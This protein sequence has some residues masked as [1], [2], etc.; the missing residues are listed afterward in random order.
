MGLI[1]I[2]NEFLS[3]TVDEYSENGHKATL[4]ATDSNGL[5]DIAYYTYWFDDYSKEFGSM[6]FFYKIAQTDIAPFIRKITVRGE[7]EGVN[8]TQNWDLA[9][10]LKA[11]PIFTHLEEFNLPLNDSETHHQ[12]IVTY[13]DMYNENGALGFLLDAAPKLKSLTAPSAPSANFFERENHSLTELNLQ[14]G[15]THQNFIKNLAASTCFSSVAKL[16]FRDYAQTYMDDYEKDCV[17]YEQ[18]EALFNATGLPMLKEITLIAT[19]IT[20]EQQAALAKQAESKGIAL[21]FLAE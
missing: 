10:L 17:P 7:D 18:Y 16:T 15:Y 1:D 19:V 20:A 2:I 6:P 11:K 9:T 13:D 12:K 4:E 3:K 14:S 21:S 5:I 8:G